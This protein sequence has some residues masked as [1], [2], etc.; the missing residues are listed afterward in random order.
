VRAFHRRSGP[1]PRHAGGSAGPGGHTSHPAVAAATAASVGTGTGSSGGS[2]RS[3]AAAGHPAELPTPPT[4]RQKSQSPLSSWSGVFELGSSRG[5]SRKS[6]RRCC[7]R[8]RF[9]FMARHWHQA[10]ACRTALF[11][12]YRPVVRRNQGMTRHGAR[13]PRHKAW[14]SAASCF[15]SAVGDTPLTR[16][17]FCHFGV[18]RLR[19]RPVDH[20]RKRL[21]IPRVRRPRRCRNRLCSRGREQGAG[22]FGTKSGA[23]HVCGLQLHL[24]SWVVLF[25]GVLPLILVLHAYHLFVH[26]IE[27]GE[28]GWPA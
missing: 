10:I 26:L 8:R 13:A 14:H 18:E 24:E 6:R 1:P 5:D 2:V 25:T 16:G 19:L 17:L 28:N 3:D 27:R 7:C 12:R 21:E 23:G 9:K 4:P 22:D 15:S 20:G 11:R